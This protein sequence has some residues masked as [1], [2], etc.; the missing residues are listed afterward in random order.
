MAGLM[1]AIFISAGPIPGIDSTSDYLVYYGSW[2]SDKIFRAK[3]FD[4][5]ILEPSN[6]TAEQLN[7][8][9]AG[10][11]GLIGTDDD[12]VI[13]AY[14]SIGEVSSGNIAGDGSGPCYYDASG[15]SIVYEHRGYA[16]F[17]L[18]DR[19]HDGYPDRNG[20]WGSYYVNAG[21]TAWWGFVES[22]A[23]A[24]FAKGADGLFLDTIDT[25]SPWGN[26]SWTAQGM[27]T[28]IQHLSELYPGKYL[29]ANRGL[30]YFDPT[31]PAHAWNIRPYI[32]GD[33]FEC[34]YTE[35]DWDNNRGVVSPYFSNNRD[36]WAYYVNLEAH[37][38]DGFTVFALD[39][40]NPEQSDYETMLANQIQVT[41]VDQGW[42]DYVSEVYLDDVYYGV[43]HHHPDG[44]RN[45]PTWNTVIGLGLVSSETTSVTL[46]W[47]DVTDQS[48]PVHFNIYY[49]TAEFSDPSEATDTL[50]HVD[51][52]NEPYGSYTWR[53]TIYN[54]APST[55]YYFMVRAEDSANPPHEDQ[56]RVVHSITTGSGNVSTGIIIDGVFDDWTSVPLLDSVHQENSGDGT[57]PDGDLVDMWATSD[58]VNLY[59]SY[60]VAGEIDFGGY[61]YHIFIDTDMNT[62]TGYRGPD[63]DYSVGADY[64]VE[65]GGLWHYS[66]SGG[67][68]WSWESAGSI[69]YAISGG[70]IELA[71]PF[72]IMGISPGAHIGSIFNINLATSPYSLTDIAP[73]EYT[74]YYYPIIVTSIDESDKR[75][76]QNVA[77]FYARNQLHVYLDEASDIT[78]YSIDGRKIR[79]WKRLSP[80]NKVLQLNLASGVYILS[81]KTNGQRVVRKFAVIR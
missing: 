63:G 72:S 48:E 28:L 67:S 33:M 6:I 19:D 76:E 36:Y 30:F 71:I 44:D 43:F 29:V 39:Y 52:V 61:F 42:V 60:L 7:E 1:L 79:E 69:Q 24:A 41:I 68:N 73:D 80:G 55:T 17:Y 9:K 59:F 5:V 78:V 27:S 49:S 47:G 2:D 10:H 15:D 81:L 38:P 40:L 34:Y 74:I 31:Q 23:D 25:A 12:V 57:S 37:Q 75:T 46:R 11:D 62:S 51:A 14:V 18:D 50:F 77:V 20:T 45:P 21:D 64:M 13:I 53:Y 56:N 70:R 22:E 26:Y 58:S 4:L 8:I 65:N 32:S 35:W 66:G 54:L 16:S 3:D